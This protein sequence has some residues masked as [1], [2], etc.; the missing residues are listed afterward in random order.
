[1]FTTL[2]F[3]SFFSKDSFDEVAMK[4]ARESSARIIKI[5]DLKRDYIFL[6]AREKSEFE[7]SHIKDAINVGYKSFD[8]KKLNLDKKKTFVVYCSIG[9]RSGK[10]AA[11]LAESGFDVYNLYGGIFNWVNNQQPIFNIKGEV[12]V[13]HSYSKN[14]SEYIKN[15]DIRIND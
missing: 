6:D 1:M 5:A 11:I 13:I 7:V 10:I 14:W 9:Y 3:L 4:M 15:K 8:L 12:K 2:L